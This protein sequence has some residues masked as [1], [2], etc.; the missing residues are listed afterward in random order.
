M[1]I[2]KEALT[3]KCLSNC[4]QTLE[5]EF[6]T[7]IAAAID[8]HK[9]KPGE[10]ERLRAIY[11]RIVSMLKANTVAKAARMNELDF[12][13][14]VRAR[15][16]AQIWGVHESSWLAY[17]ECLRKLGKLSPGY[18]LQPLVDLAKNCGWWAPYEDVVIMQRKFTEIHLSGETLHNDKGPAVA[19]CDGFKIWAING[20]LVDEQ[21]VMRPETQTLEQI[22]EE[23][24][25]ECRRIR[26][27]RFGWPRYLSE[28]KAEV[29]DNR[30]NQVEKV[31]ETLLRIAEP[32]MVALMCACPS[33]GRV[34]CIEVPPDTGSC[35]AAQK[36]L[37]SKPD[38]LATFG[39]NELFAT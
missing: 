9:L 22:K 5:A 39:D 26:I 27:E 34:Y 1:E 36:W 10:V 25:E 24:N 29:V 14:A 6:D 15:V 13:S 7:K 38:W 20:V 21:I 16:P 35:A 18:K 23:T 2:D 3:E 37:E 4:Q 33:T 11:R 17:Y 28:M 31:Q 19:Y 12:R 32:A 8:E 30:V